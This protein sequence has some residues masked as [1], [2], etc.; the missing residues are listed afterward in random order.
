MYCQP[1]EHMV[2]V[3]GFKLEPDYSP[4][5]P[6]PPEPPDADLIPMTPVSLEAAEPPEPTDSTLAPTEPPRD[7]ST[8]PP[9]MPLQ[10]LRC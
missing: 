1:G 4:M 5:V 8:V 10:G 6:E 3:P 9:R 2:A 7:R